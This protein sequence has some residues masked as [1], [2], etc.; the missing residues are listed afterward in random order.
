[1]NMLIRSSLIIV[2][3][4]LSAAFIG[5]EWNPLNWSEPTRILFAGIVLMVLLLFTN[6]IQVDFKEDDADDGPR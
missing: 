3:T 1:M 5:L 4:Y 2:L 6:H